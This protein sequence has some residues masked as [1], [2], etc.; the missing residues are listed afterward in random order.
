MAKY[1]WRKYEH[2]GKQ[3]WALLPVEA[4]NHYSF[5]RIASVYYSPS[6]KKFVGAFYLPG[7][8]GGPDHGWGYYGTAQSARRRMG[9]RLNSLWECPEIIDGAPQ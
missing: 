9:E 1:I 5:E 6:L 2:F 8:T 3:R 7:A 4:S